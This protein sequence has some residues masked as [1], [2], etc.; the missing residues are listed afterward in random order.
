MAEQPFDLVFMD[1]QMPEMDGLSATQQIREQEKTEPH[2][3][4][5][6]CLG[7]RE[8][9]RHHASGGSAPAIR[10]QRRGRRDRADGD[11]EECHHPVGR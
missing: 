5:E 8:Q 2:L 4:D 9:L 10:H 6:S 11:D 7:E 1:I 3:G